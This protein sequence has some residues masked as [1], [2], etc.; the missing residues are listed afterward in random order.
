[1]KKVFRRH[2]QFS[3]GSSAHPN[4]LVSRRKGFSVLVRLFMQVPYVVVFKITP[5]PP[6]CSI[7]SRCRRHQRK[8][9]HTATTTPV[10]CSTSI[11][12]SLASCSNQH[13]SM[14]NLSSLEYLQATLPCNKRKERIG[15]LCK[16][17]LQTNTQTFVE[18]GFNG[19]VSN[20]SLSY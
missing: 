14:L 7:P 8:K 2:V 15:A 3:P 18:V 4:T 20:Y 13:G 12:L 9:I 10:S 5:A 6:F 17:H 16:K 11:S 1:M 19:G